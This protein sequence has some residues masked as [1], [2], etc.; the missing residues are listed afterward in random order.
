MPNIKI[1]ISCRV[2]GIT[3]DFLNIHCVPFTGKSKTLAFRLL[4]IRFSEGAPFKN[5]FSFEINGWLLTGVPTTYI[6]FLCFT[7]YKQETNNA[8]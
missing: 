1:I 3:L 7:F 2:G 8:L 4:G 5:I 6:Q